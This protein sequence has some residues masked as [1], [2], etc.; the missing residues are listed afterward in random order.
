MFMSAYNEDICILVEELLGQN[1][2]NLRKKY[3]K[4]SFATVAAIGIQLVI[5]DSTLTSIFR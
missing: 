5:S 3:G 4:L 2:E 1:L